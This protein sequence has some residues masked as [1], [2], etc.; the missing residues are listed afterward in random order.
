MILP[1]IPRLA[2]STSSKASRAR[3]IGDETFFILKYV[4]AGVVVATGFVHLA[5]ESIV[6][7][8]SPCL[9]LIYQPLAPVLQMVGLALVFL[10]DCFV[11]RYLHRLRKK[12]Q[13]NLE[14]AYARQANALQAQLSNRNGIDRAAT[15][16]TADN[17]RYCN[18]PPSYSLT[19]GSNENS[20][21]ASSDQVSFDSLEKEKDL[22]R[23]ENERLDEKTRELEVMIIEGGIV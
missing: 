3:R 7:L 5:Y 23:I 22:A 17:G 21:Q 10:I 8:E 2:S 14:E 13:S 15:C 6:E 4:G 1:F 19:S 20:D 9:N 12:N 18:A 16:T 11:A